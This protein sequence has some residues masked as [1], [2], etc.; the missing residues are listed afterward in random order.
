MPRH[1]KDDID[2]RYGADDGN[3]IGLTRAFSP[4]DDD[5]PFGEPVSTDPFD[6]GGASGASAA[7]EAEASA[8]DRVAGASD[9]GRRGRHA[10]HAAS[11]A[12][13]PSDFSDAS[14]SGE[15]VFADDHTASGFSSEGGRARPRNSRG[16]AHGA[17]DAGRADA[18][19]SMSVFDESADVMASSDKIPEYLRK[20]RRMRRILIVVIVIL[21]LLLAAGCVLTWQL[22]EMADTTATQQT[23]TSS[24]DVTSLGESDGTEDASTTTT[25]ETTVPSL[26]SLLGMTQDEAVE[27]LQHGAQVTSTQEVNEEGNPI[28]T[29]SRVVLTSEP[30]D[31]R[32]GSPTVY[33]GLDEGGLVIQAGYSA[34]T[35]SL[36]YGSL[37]FSDAVR[38][39]SII[40]KTLAE[41]GLEV[42]VGTVELPEDK[43]E[44]STYASDGTT[45]TME[46]CSFSGEVDVDGVAHQWS[47]VL[48]YDYSMANATG[49]LADTIRTIYVYVNA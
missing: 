18:E 40:E 38:N 45:L 5:D 24:G 16:S 46:Y 28:K 6:E 47:A 2:E 32:S 48:S 29:E 26:V 21:V 39:E 12:S 34:A 49:N 42:P 4:V 17:H 8:P 10:R 1:R 3:A 13:E 37:S 27:F 9:A 30:S 25:K 35:S 7:S 44:Y 31:T 23:Q 19:V 15:R 33:L 43:M 22:F 41:A 36:G 11:D 14:S 20:S